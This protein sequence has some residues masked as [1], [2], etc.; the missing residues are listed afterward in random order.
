MVQVREAK[1]KALAGVGTPINELVCRVSILNF[2]RRIAENI[3]LIRAAKFD[4]CLLRTSKKGFGF[5][6]DVHVWITPRDIENANLTI[7]LGY[8]IIGH[9]DWHEGQIKVFAAFDDTEFEAQ[10]E[11][12]NNL[13]VSGRLPVSQNNLKLFAMPAEQKMK[14]LINETSNAADL[15]IMG[16]NE[17]YTKSEDL[18]FFSGYDQLGNILFVGTP[19]EPVVK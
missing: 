10:S 6:R 1:N 9:K 5:Q 13:I 18:G 19:N 8:I 16:F 4:L 12:L 15:V 14:D 7:V 17:R 2:A 11:R 3:G